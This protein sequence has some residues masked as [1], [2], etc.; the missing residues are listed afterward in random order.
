MI[1]VRLN[2]EVRFTASPSIQAM[3]KVRKMREEEQRQYKKTDG[4]EKRT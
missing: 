4:Y 3:N 2:S 1:T